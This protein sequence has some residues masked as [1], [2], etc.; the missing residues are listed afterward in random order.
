LKASELGEKLTR[1]I[2]E[3]KNYY[4]Q[5]ILSRIVLHNFVR[6]SIRKYIIAKKQ[7]ETKAVYDN[8]YQRG[9]L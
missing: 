8:L 9:L 1:D 2:K 7:D 5:N 4:S 3:N 6:P